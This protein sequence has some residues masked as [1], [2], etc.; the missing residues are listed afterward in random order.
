V[1]CVSYTAELAEPLDDLAHA[2]HA[3]GGREEEASRALERSMAI[4]QKLKL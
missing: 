4:Q 3:V 2:L 1:A